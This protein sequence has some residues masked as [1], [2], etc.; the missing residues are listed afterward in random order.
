MTTPFLDPDPNQPARSPTVEWL[1]RK[2]LNITRV[3]GY[4][5]RSAEGSGLQKD[6]FLKIP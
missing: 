5:S 3:E 2:N 6:Q 4:P 1:C